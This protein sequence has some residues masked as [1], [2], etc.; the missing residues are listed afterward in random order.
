[1]IRCI[2]AVIGVVAWLGL[3]GAQEPKKADRIRDLKLEIAA[4]KTKLAILEKEL[5]VLEGKVPLPYIGP[6]K[7]N[8][9]TS[10]KIGSKG[11]MG[12]H[13]YTV[14]ETVSNAAILRVSGFA[15][16]V[17]SIP[18]KNL[19]EGQSVKMTGEWEVIAVMNWRGRKLHHVQ[20]AA[21]GTIVPE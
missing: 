5:T 9:S 13:V 1:M 10:L 7:A 14:Q 15:F 21:D 18:T 19:A 11:S 20:P 2:A 3:T 17:S 12:D 4:A 16:V 6:L 8:G